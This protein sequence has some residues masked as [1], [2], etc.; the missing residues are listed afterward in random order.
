MKVSRAFEVQLILE[1]KEE[2]FKRAV[3][4]L[5][6]ARNMVGRAERLLVTSNSTWQSRIKLALIRTQLHHD[7]ARLYTIHGSDQHGEFIRTCQQLSEVD[8]AFLNRVGNF[9][10]RGFPR[11]LAYYQSL[12]I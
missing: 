11:V 4:L 10:S 2:Y 8:I 7:L 5:S 9:K 1:T 12:E 6:L 3:N